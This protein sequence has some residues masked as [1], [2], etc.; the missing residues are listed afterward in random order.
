MTANIYTPSTI[1]SGI[2]LTLPCDINIM[3]ESA[4]GAI[5]YRELYFSGRDI[6][7]KRP[8][9]YGMYAHCMHVPDTPLIV[10]AGDAGH[11]IDKEFL[12]YYAYAGYSVF[13]FD[14][15][16]EDGK[17]TKY[18]FY[19]PEIDYA[20][21]ARAGSHLYKAEPDARHTSLFEWTA[22]ASY[23]LSAAIEV[24]AVPAA[25]VGLLGV[26]RGADLVWMLSAADS[27]PAAC[28]TVFSAGWEAYRDVFK[29]DENALPE[30][31]EER[32]RFL[33]GITPDAYAKF[34]RRPMLFVSSTNS[35][36]TDIE[37]A[38]DTL[39]R[40]PE[41]VYTL[42]GITPRLSG[43]TGHTNTLNIRLFFE[44]FLKNAGTIMPKKA[45]AGVENKDGAVTVSVSADSCCAVEKVTVY[46][47]ADE[48]KPA[49]RNW[50]QISAEHSGGEYRAA[51]PVRSFGRLFVFANVSYQSGFTVASNVVSKTAAE[52]RLDGAPARLI[53]VLY[54]STA[55]TDCFTVFSPCELPLHDIF[56]KECAVGLK[57]GP[58]GIKGAAPK[59]GGLAT[60][61]IGENVYR[62]GGDDSLKF[63]VFSPEKGELS[64]YVL[65]HAGGAGEH[66]H[67]CAVSLL[68][69][70]IWQP[71]VL[72]K[73]NLKT[74]EGQPLKDWGGIGMLGF[75]SENEFCI[76]NILWI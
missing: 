43:M 10:V 13:M 74:F 67:T 56:L 5:K 24:H 58:G 36:V 21:Y 63:D 16:G 42:C 40:V 29:F 51:L 75:L 41:D 46:Y 62:G 44:K 54:N 35:G 38:A 47:S 59:T 1:F 12:T 31:D 9:G 18:S 53:P 57:E 65:D 15:A 39:S 68:G 69:G 6:N 14:Y 55:G 32:E 25:P 48:I 52:L 49:A 71:V 11:K 28:C 50:N 20:N 23:A 34:T 64:V 4:D 33:A 76:N 2:D 72:R 8:R 27:R 3:N 73:E 26:G 7:G 60:Y 30:I 61:K 45:V 66:Y 37:R 19:P 17:K 22:L 70:N